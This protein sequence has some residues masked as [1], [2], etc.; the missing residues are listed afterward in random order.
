MIANIK[1]LRTANDL[2][3][4]GFSEA[5][6]RRR[7]VNFDQA[8]MSDTHVRPMVLPGRKTLT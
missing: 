4:L 1:N 7:L 2:R 5:P 8:G 6:S 3:I